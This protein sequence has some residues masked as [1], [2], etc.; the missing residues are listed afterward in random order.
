MNLKDQIDKDF[1]DAYKAKNEMIVSVLRMIKSSIKNTEI[2]QKKELTDDEIIKVL[3]KETK[4]RLDSISQYESASRPE[5]VEKEKSE[6]EI[7]KKYLPAEIDD[8]ELEQIIDTKIT[9]LNA[10]EMKDMG[11]VIAA[12]MQE[13]G[14]KADGS[15]VSA[16]VRSKLQ[17]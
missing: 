15:K 16:L 9:D 8:A 14:G 1:L 3:K 2:A 7:I 17:I 6:I 10:S 11:K 13:V 12:V 5:L 4:Q